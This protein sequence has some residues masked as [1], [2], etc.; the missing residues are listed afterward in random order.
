MKPSETASTVLIEDRL[1]IIIDA[2]VPVE[3]VGNIGGQVSLSYAEDLT[4]EVHFGHGKRVRDAL[5]SVL[6]D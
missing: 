4:R 1:Q 6:N 5:H 2:P 3:G